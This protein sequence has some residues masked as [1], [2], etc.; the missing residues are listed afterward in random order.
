MKGAKYW[1]SG[2]EICLELSRESLWFRLNWY[3]APPCS[4]KVPNCS[5]IRGCIYCIDNRRDLVWYRCCPYCFNGD[6]KIMTYTSCALVWSAGDLSSNPIPLEFNCGQQF[7]RKW[8]VSLLT[9]GESRLTLDPRNPPPESGWITQKPFSGISW[10]T[11]PFFTQVRM[12]GSGYI[13][14]GSTPREIGIARH[15]TSLHNHYLHGYQLEHAIWSWY[16]G[17]MIMLLSPN[18]SM[19]SFGQRLYGNYNLHDRL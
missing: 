15:L 5:D 16:L 1:E 4:R 17:H 18:V 14:L 3:I 8:Q 12:H 11:G 19:P 13:W 7:T 9:S 6:V 2:Y 10:R